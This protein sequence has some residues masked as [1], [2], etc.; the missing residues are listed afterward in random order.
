MRHSS[1]NSLDQIRAQI[2][3]GWRLSEILEGEAALGEISQGIRNLLRS[4]GATGNQ[5]LQETLERIVSTKQPL[6]VTGL[7]WFEWGNEVQE[8]NLPHIAL[9]CL[10]NAVKSAGIPTE[11]ARTAVVQAVE[12]RLNQ[13]MEHEQSKQWL[14]RVIKTRSDDLIGRRA[15]KLLK[16]IG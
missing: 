13:G 5:L 1:V 15:Q 14:E 11:I 16:S 7:Q 9:I 3:E 6:P 4:S 8:R 2:G 12:L 10:E